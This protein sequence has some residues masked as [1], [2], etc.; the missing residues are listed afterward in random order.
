MRAVWLCTLTQPPY[1]RANRESSNLKVSESRP[2]QVITLSL[3]LLTLTKVAIHT[4]QSIQYS[5]MQH[6]L[7]N[8][9][10]TNES[11]SVD[12][13]VAKQRFMIIWSTLNICLSY[14]LL[15]FK[16]GMFQHTRLD[17]Y[18][19]LFIILR[20]IYSVCSCPPDSSEEKMAFTFNFS[21]PCRPS[22]LL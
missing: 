16:L 10:L 21:D 17:E 8:K 6:K 1:L 15:T 12:F 19:F 18:L 11:V 7:H 20:N 3:Y 5:T 4:S 2:S 13:T 22:C 9:T 14:L